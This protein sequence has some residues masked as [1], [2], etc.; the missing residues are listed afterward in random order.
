MIFTNTQTCN[1]EKIRP[2]KDLNNK[3][4]IIPCKLKKQEAFQNLD[5]LLTVGKPEES[6]FDSEGNISCDN[7]RQQKN[8]FQ[9]F[10]L[11]RLI[12]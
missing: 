4:R 9:C 12:F 10:A 1:L 6:L 3:A 5:I 7:V 11:L 2:E 8:F